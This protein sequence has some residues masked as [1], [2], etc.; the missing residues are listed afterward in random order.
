MESSEVVMSTDLVAGILWIWIW[1]LPFVTKVILGKLLNSLSHFPHFELI[2]VSTSYIL[3]GR[4]KKHIKQC[5]FM[6]SCFSRV[7]LFATLKTVAHQAP[8][9]MGSSRQYWSRL[10]C[11]PLEDLPTTGIQTQVSYIP[12]IG[13]QVLYHKCHPGSSS[14]ICVCQ[15]KCLHTVIG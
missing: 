4:L 12:C 10:L 2:I 1:T 6:V 15:I 13:R 14:A 5:Y 9:S 8:L 7:L 3:E 11:P